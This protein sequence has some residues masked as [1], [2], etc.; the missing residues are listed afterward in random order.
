VKNSLIFLVPMV[1]GSLLPLITFPIFTRI[2]TVEDY[3]AWALAVAFGGFLSG[4]ANFGLVISFE[5]NFF[6]STSREERSRLLYSSMA[7]VVST[8]ALVGGITW[9]LRARI[10]GFFTDS[11][12]YG[13]LFF[14][15]FCATGVT[16]LQAYYFTYLKNT[17]NAGAHT[18]YTLA[19][20]VLM[21]LLALL[22]V[23]Y[24]R[25][26]PVGLVYAQV[27][28]GGSVLAVLM[29]R[30]LRELPLG[31]SG[32][33]L[34]DSLKLSYPLTPL[35]LLKV[36]SSQFDKYVIGLLG[37]LGGVGVYSIGQ[38]IARLAFNFSTALENVFTPQTFQRMFK[39]AE[40][41]P[42]T[43]GTFLT[44]FAFVSLAGALL[45]VLF[46]EEAVRLLAPAVFHGAIPIV[47]VLAAYYGLL[48]FGKQPQLIF[49]KKTG[50]ISMLS[51]LGLGTNVVLVVLGVQFFGAVGAAWGIA[52]AAIVTLSLRHLMGQRYYEIRWEYRRVGSMLAV[53]FGSTLLMVVVRALDLPYVLRLGTKLACC[54][55]YFALGVHSKVL[56]R[57]NVA[58]VRSAL[59]RRG[60]NEEGVI[61]S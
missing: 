24:M 16:S 5:R 19:D 45:L 38:Q 30:F 6:E 36:V 9:V 49:A 61:S 46:S 11:P 42:E 34:L 44:P 8:L 23:A 40:G 37:S 14:W 53:L 54:G 60:S 47:S 22:F 48:F 7:F 28:A 56:T 15:A 57:A 27:L 3:G 33:L 2:L 10:S 4:L 12:E 55:V 17:E 26:G 39:H 50:I 32:R 1:V 18:R 31:F 21:T 58:L 29:G 43:V 13:G 35:L 25:L 59:S 52:A 20:R 51:F 41:G